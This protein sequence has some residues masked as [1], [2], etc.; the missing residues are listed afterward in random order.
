[1]MIIDSVNDS[2]QSETT[3]Q[4]IMQF[5]IAH[6]QKSHDVVQYMFGYLAGKISTL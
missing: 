2:K 5:G 1:M 6:G 3:R 4:M